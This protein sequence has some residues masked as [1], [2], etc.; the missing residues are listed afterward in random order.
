MGTTTCRLVRAHQ[1]CP[2]LRYTERYLKPN[3]YTTQERIQRE[4]L[5]EATPA[6]TGYEPRPGIADLKLAILTRDSYRCQ[7]CTEQVNLATSH[8]DH[9]RPVRRFRRPVE[10]NRLDNLQTLCLPCHRIKT[11]A[12]Q[13][14]ESRVQ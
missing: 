3:P 1:D 12:D 9:I 11:E 6:W 8:L 2:T 4:E 7:N 10:A 5:P 14:R 13:L